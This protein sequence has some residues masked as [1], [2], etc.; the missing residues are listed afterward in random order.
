[1]KKVERSDILDYVTY[2]EQRAEIRAAAMRAKDA[3]RIHLGD[4]LTFLFEN[5]ETIRYQILEM[6]RA[7]KIVRESDIRHELDTYNELVGGPGELCATLLIEIEDVDDR[8]RKLAEWV[9]LPAKL[10]LKLADGSRAYA[11][12]DERQNE[13]AKISSVQFLKFVCGGQVPVAIGCEHPAYSIE[14]DLEDSQA[15]ALCADLAR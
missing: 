4:Y 8:A 5:T 7:E 13:E 11:Q 9:G 14:T 6:V 10:Y 15:A 2:E 1:M 12:P 3:R